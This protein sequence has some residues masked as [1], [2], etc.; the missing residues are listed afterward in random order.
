MDYVRVPPD[1]LGKRL[2]AVQLPDGTY[3]EAVVVVDEF[4]NLIR[5]APAS[6]Q[7]AQLKAGDVVA[8][9]AVDKDTPSIAVGTSGKLGG[10]TIAATVPVKAE[11]KTV[12]GGVETLHDVVFTNEAVLSYTWEPPHDT[13]ITL[14]GGAGN[15]FRVTLTNLDTRDTA[16]LYATIYYD[17]A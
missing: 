4:G 3:A 5:L 7:H 9:L 11:I 17:E 8:G 13:Y 10:V 14:A 12:S 1:G 15:K 6:P 16:D 2:A